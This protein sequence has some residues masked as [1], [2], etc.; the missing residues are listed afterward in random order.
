MVA[1]AFLPFVAAC[2]PLNTFLNYTS[3]R[4]LSDEE[5]GEILAIATSRIERRIEIIEKANGK[6]MS[7]KEKKELRKT[8]IAGVVGALNQE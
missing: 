3:F 4:W 5:K 2:E 7:E 1:L 6:Q 8:V